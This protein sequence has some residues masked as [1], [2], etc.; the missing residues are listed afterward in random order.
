VGECNTSREPEEIISRLLDD[1]NSFL[2]KYS[3]ARTAFG[4]GTMNSKGY[5]T[6]L[7]N[8]LKPRPTTINHIYAWMDAYEGSVVRAY[9][10]GVVKKLKGGNF[11]IWSASGDACFP[12][13][14]V[15]AKHHLDRLIAN[16]TLKAS[17]DTLIRDVYSQTYRV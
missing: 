17:D 7:Y 4:L 16:G 9:D 6:R 3:M 5:L 12:D 13:G 2:A 11:I 10:E 15:V 8:G 1:I 14:T